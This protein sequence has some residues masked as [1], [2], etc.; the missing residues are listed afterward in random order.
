MAKNIEKT[1]ARD[2][3][4]AARIQR[5]AEL[6][7]LSVRQVRRVNECESE[8]ETVIS[9]LMALQEGENKLIQEV[10]KLVPLT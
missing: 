2:T 10:K 8:N 7:G 3:I 1:K 5:T 6:T 4:K 9:V